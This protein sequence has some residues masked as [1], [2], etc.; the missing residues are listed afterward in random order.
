MRTDVAG[1]KVSAGLSTFKRTKLYSEQECGETNRGE[2]GKRLGD[3]HPERT[4][5]KIREPN[6]RKWL[7][8]GTSRTVHI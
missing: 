5:K 6:K 8:I 2:N 7:D 4:A 3:W 1:K